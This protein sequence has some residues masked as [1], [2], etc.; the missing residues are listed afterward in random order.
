M[1]NLGCRVASGVLRHER[2]CA[3]PP[4]TNEHATCDTRHHHSIKFAKK[5]TF[6]EKNMQEQE[7]TEDSL[8]GDTPDKETGAGEQK[9]QEQRSEDSQVFIPPPIV[10]TSSDGSAISLPPRKRRLVLDDAVRDED[11]QEAQISRKIQKLNP[12][13][14]LKQMMGLL[15]QQ[16]SSMVMS[17]QSSIINL[18]TSLQTSIAMQA[19]NTSKQFEKAGR[20]LEEQ[21]TKIMSAETRL[22]DAETK[23]SQLIHNMNY[24]ELRNNSTLRAVIKFLVERMMNTSVGIVCARP[25]IVQEELLVVVHL[26]ALSVMIKTYFASSNFGTDAS[27]IELLRDWFKM[28][29]TY[30]F[31][32]HE[33]KMFDALFPVK[34]YKNKNSRK[35]SWCVL[36]GKELVKQYRF[37]MDQFSCYPRILADVPSFEKVVKKKTSRLCID[38]DLGRTSRPAFGYEWVAEMLE[39]HN[40]AAIQMHKLLHPDSQVVFEPNKFVHFTWKFE[41]DTDTPVKQFADVYEELTDDDENDE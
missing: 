14:D 34:P 12:D 7:R 35:R 30:D 33:E 20:I 8:L 28:L 38:V 39:P 6:R 3:R 41:V 11:T 22:K 1:E 36:Y 16:S 31:D 18:Q 25:M 37:C 21:S 15:M 23:I 27:K 29:G 2:T 10:A 26:H 19:E 32:E 5:Y 4:R 13:T 9:E 24:P 40:Q 17:L